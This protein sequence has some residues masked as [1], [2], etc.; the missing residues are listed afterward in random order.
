MPIS[1]GNS[2]CIQPLTHELTYIYELKKMN[3]IIVWQ[4]TLDWFYS[5]VTSNLKR[6]YLF[7]GF[8]TT[9]PIQNNDQM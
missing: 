3:E 5:C 7:D 2:A 1:V 8:P 4:V 9:K 6:K